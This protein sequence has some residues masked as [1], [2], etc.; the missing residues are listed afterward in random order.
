M[1]CF[2]CFPDQIFNHPFQSQCTPVIRRINPADTIFLQRLYFCGKNRSTSTTKNADMAAT[3]FVEQVTE[4][5][6]KFHMSALVGCEG[7]GLYIFFDG[8]FGNFMYTSVMAQVNDFDTFGLQD[9]AHDIDSSI[10]PV[11]KR[12]SRNNP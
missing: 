11:E 8:C 5:F 2:F 3:T 6:E 12:G 7:D 4:V 1:K 9:P 10:M